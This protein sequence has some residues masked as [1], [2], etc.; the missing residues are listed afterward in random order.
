MTVMD[1]WPLRQVLLYTSKLIKYCGY[2]HL[3][4]FMIV[5]AILASILDLQ[6]LFAIET[7]ISFSLH[8][9]TCK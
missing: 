3:I 1:E 6:T 4:Y 5:M 2:G 8:D 9:K 7:S